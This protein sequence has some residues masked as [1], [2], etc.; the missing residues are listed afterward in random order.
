MKRLKVL[1]AEEGFPAEAVL[2]A[3]APDGQPVDLDGCVVLVLSSHAGCSLEFRTVRSLR[4]PLPGER[5][6]AV[7]GAAPDR[8]GAEALL[9][10]LLERCTAETGTPDLK[11]WYASLPPEAWT[12]GG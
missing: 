9:A 11:A 8:E 1:A 10:S 12:D 7:V 6:T 3:A 5:V 4:K 2:A